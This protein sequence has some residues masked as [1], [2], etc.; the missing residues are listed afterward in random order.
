M[1]GVVMLCYCSYS[2]NWK[3]RPKRFV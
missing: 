2:T 1:K 3:C